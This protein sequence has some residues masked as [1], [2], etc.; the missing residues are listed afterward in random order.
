MKPETLKHKGNV[1]GALLLVVVRL[2]RGGLLLAAVRL[3]RV[4]FL[5]VVAHAV[6]V[7][8]SLES[9]A[10]FQDHLAVVSG[11][12]LG[13]RRHGGHVIARVGEQSRRDLALAVGVGV[14]LALVVALGVALAV[15]IGVALDVRR[16]RRLERSGRVKR[17]GGTSTGFRTGSFAPEKGGD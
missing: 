5:L 11:H 4:L 17:R 8:I 13:P 3:R 10:A 12:R 1:A 6:R 14:A 9:E 16:F 15:T 2:V 7:A